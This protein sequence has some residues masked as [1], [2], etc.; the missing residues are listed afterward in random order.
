MSV[1]TD[2]RRD[3]VVNKGDTRVVLFSLLA[4][5]RNSRW[6]LQAT[7]VPPILP[8]TPS[9]ILAKLRDTS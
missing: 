1:V 8:A 4:D 7:L 3:R 5:R 6:T 2:P 9:G